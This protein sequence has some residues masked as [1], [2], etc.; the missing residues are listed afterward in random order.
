[1]SAYLKRL[2][3]E[4]VEEPSEHPSAYMKIVNIVEVVD[5]DGNPW[6]PVP[7][8]DPL[9]VADGQGANW[10]NTN[11]YKVG[12][13]VEGKTAAFTGGVGPVTYR[14]RFQFK[15]TGSD[16][17]V[18]ESWTTTTNAKNSVTYT[19]TETG[20]IKL[21]SQASDS[22]DPVVQLNSVTGVKTVVA[23]TIGTVTA[24][25]D[26]GTNYDYDV[27]TPISTVSGATHTFGVGISGDA[28]PSYTWSVKQGDA[29]L[30]PNDSAC[31]A[32]VNNPTGGSLLQIQVDIIDDN[33]SDSPFSFRYVFAVN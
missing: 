17:W 3:I 18:N 22:S 19:L 30:T 26:G 29:T 4:E 32:V 10:V 9:E 16:T 24:T 2:Q 23:P 15:A 13:T 20:Q 7:P 11:V 27:G 8:V 14:Y 28:N 21:Q 6:E 25:Y 33:A 31:T 12:Q 1:M 5:S